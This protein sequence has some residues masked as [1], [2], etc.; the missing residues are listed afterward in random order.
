M[1]G[2]RAAIVAAAVAALSVPA[3]AAGPRLLLDRADLE[4]SPFGGLARLRLH[5]SA[6]Q[7]EGSLIQVGGADPLILTINGARRREAHLTGRYAAADGATAVILVI[8]TGWEMRDEVDAI[9]E[10]VK[11]LLSKLPPGS[12]VAIITYG[13]NVEGG[14]RLAA[15]AKLQDLEAD[16][17]PADPQLLAAVERAITTLARAKAPAEGVP[18]RRM[19][20]V[21][22]DGKDIEDDPDRYRAVG[23]R[24]MREEIRI[25]SLAYSPVDNR[26]PLLGLGE[27]SKRSRGT[28]RW[29]R[30]REGFQPQID[31]LVA[32]INHQYVLTWFL[33]ADQVVNKRIAVSYRDLASNEIRV[34][35][36][37]CGG[38][39]CSGGQLCARGRCIAMAG[40]GGRGI[41]GWLLVIGGGAV[42]VLLLLGVI[43]SLMVRARNRSARPALPGGPVPGGYGPAPAVGPSA[44]LYVNAGPFQ[45]QRM[46]LRHGFTVGSARGTDLF[47]PGDPG[48]AP[49]HAVFL[50]DATGTWAIMDRSNQGV[51]VNGVRVAEARLGHGNL[52]RIGTC[53]LRYLTG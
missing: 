28:F 5:V 37:E 43:G 10:A 44:V 13:E 25:H 24:A 31:T 35:K 48:V 18:L 49:H 27:L 46:P 34:K 8:E 7:L 21:V 20:V 38:K 50:V 32:E 22:S 33:P 19:I 53:E 15:S 6:V 23:E 40:G 51:F 16:G 52:I 1:F 26:R 42:G 36:V 29:V 3:E 41:L 2:S 17:A 9:G 11:G 30:S 12:Q 4:P 47:L 45:G 14:H 39:S